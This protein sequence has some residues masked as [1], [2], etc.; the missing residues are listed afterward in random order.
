[1]SNLLN[2]GVDGKLVRLRTGNLNV[3]AILGRKCTAWLKANQKTRSPRAPLSENS[4][5]EKELLSFWGSLRSVICGPS[6]Q[7]KGCK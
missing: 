3:T 6:A 1:M 7:R 4:N 5:L 2:A